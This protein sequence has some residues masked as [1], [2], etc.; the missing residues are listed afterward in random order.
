MTSARNIESDNIL[1][2]EVT[3]HWAKKQNIASEYFKIIESTNL[4]AKE[5][6]FNENSFNEHLIVYFAEAQSAGRGRG[7]NS[8]VNSDTKG[9]QLLSTWSFMID[10][11]PH[12]TV[13]PMIGLALFRAASSTWPFLNWNLKAPND[14]Y[15]NHK[16]VAGLLIETVSQG[17]DHRLLLGLGFNVISAPGVVTN[18]CSLA[19]ELS[20]HTPLLAQDW[21]SFL[22]RLLFEFSFSLQMSFEPLNSTSQ[23]ALLTALNKHPLLAEPYKAL[24]ELGNLS[25][26]T[27]KISWLEL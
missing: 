13:S 5:D 2:G 25:T 3:H 27:K 12:P 18:S 8:W 11:A 19:S 16:K 7:Q 26:A 20:V 24:D 1:I 23:A 14:L 17:E 10:S 21:I 15:I 4:K 6:A 9:G 22:E